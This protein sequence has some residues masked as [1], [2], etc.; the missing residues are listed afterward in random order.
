VTE[1]QSNADAILVGIPMLGILLFSF[2]RLD[3]S[4]GHR[5][6]AKQRATL[7]GHPL[8]YTDEQGEFVCVE[9]DGG[10]S[11]GK[12]AGEPAGLWNKN[13][14][15]GGKSD[16]GPGSRK[17]PQMLIRRVSPHWQEKDSWE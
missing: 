9:P 7:M 16:S 4:I 11:Q 12:P 1:L 10:V 17:K 2:F 6:R 3:G 8:S 5:R 13:P 14:V 15:R